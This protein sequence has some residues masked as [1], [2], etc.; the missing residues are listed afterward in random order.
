MG[1]GRQLGRR[2]QGLH[3]LLGVRALEADTDLEPQVFRYWQAQLLEI[4]AELE[5]LRPSQS[6]P[7]ITARE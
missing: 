4:A 3:A 7:R 6:W 5:G 1:L 2:N